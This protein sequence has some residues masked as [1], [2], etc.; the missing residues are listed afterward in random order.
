MAERITVKFVENAAVR[1]RAS[2]WCQKAALGKR[3]A[4]VYF[5]WSV[6]VGVLLAV[7]AGSLAMLLAIFSGFPVPVPL[8]VLAGLVI[9]YALFKLWERV[10][11]RQM[12]SAAQ[13]GKTG[14]PTYE[15]DATGFLMRDPEREH[16]TLW[17]RVSTMETV[18]DG[19]F[20]SVAGIVY[21]V[22]K[23]SW[24]DEAAYEA[25]T[26]KIVTWWEQAKTMSATS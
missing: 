22:T 25:D 9:Y 26:N 1:N 10:A 8:A 24:A 15:F 11:L 19:L 12:A 23:E 2:V 6:F 4:K 13:D 14:D 3:L 20:M 17:R 18:P 16:R 5:V 21:Y 7:G